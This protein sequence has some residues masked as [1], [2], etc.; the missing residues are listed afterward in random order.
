MPSRADK[1]L[2]LSLLTAAELR[3]D[4]H[5]LLKGK[6]LDGDDGVIDTILLEKEDVKQACILKLERLN[7]SGEACLHSCSNSHQN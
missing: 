4:D 2:A 7:N 5:A 6:I 1:E 3:Q